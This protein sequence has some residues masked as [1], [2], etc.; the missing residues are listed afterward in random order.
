[1]F[2]IGEVKD[3]FV[4]RDT[5]SRLLG[6][7]PTRTRETDEIVAPFRTFVGPREME[8]HQ[9][10]SDKAKAIIALL[11]QFHVIA[12]HPQPGQSKANALAEVLRPGRQSQPQG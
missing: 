4:I 6:A 7:F 1:M 8:L 3:I 2:G 12:K 5:F 11:K 9:M 10:Y